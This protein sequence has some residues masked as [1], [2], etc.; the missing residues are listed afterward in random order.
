MT[1]FLLLSN[2]CGIVKVGL[3][4]WQEVRSVGYDCCWA[5]E[6]HSFQDSSPAGLMTKF[7]TPSTWKARCACMYL[8][9]PGTAWP[10]YTPKHW[11]VSQ[12]HIALFE[13]FFVSYIMTDGQMVSLSW[14]QEPVC[15]PW[16]DFYYFQ[17]V[18]TLLIWVSSDEK[19]CM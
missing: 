7:E 14:C 11:V 8:Y 12:G 15:D 13:Y 10:S 6:A 16:S 9:P 1:G 18:V 4:H 17:T 5:S 2:T 19:M 3:P